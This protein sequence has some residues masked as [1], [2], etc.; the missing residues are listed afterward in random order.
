MEF[1]VAHW[2]F[3]DWRKIALSVVLFAEIIYFLLIRYAFSKNDREEGG[4]IGIKV[5]SLVGGLLITCFGLGLITIVI[6]VIRE[7]THLTTLSTIGVIGLI[8]AYF[9]LNYLIGS[10]YNKRLLKK[11]LEADKH[12]RKRH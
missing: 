5:L 10:E 9:A 3:D 1:L 4:F 2:L 11:E 8:V 12:K 6:D 7:N